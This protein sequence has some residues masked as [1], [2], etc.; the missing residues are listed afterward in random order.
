MEPEH[1]YRRTSDPMSIAI[2]EGLEV[3][4]MDEKR[5]GT[6]AE[7]SEEHFKVDV[8]M[9]RDYW[10]SLATVASVQG[11][12]LVV[13]FDEAVLDDYKLSSPAGVA[14]SPMLAEQMNAIPSRE[15]EVAGRAEQTAGYDADPDRPMPDA[16]DDSLPRA[17]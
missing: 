12:R 15:A 8:R 2:R 10:L 13:Q 5:L 1:E 4:T 17:Q 7:V 3:C 9:A 11:D 6:V 14:A 16:R